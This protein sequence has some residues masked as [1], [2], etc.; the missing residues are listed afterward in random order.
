MRHSQT[1]AAER[2]PQQKRN[3]QPCGTSHLDGTKAS[4]GRLQPVAVLALCTVPSSRH[5]ALLHSVQIKRGLGRVCGALQC[6]SLSGCLG[7]AAVDRCTAPRLFRATSP[8]HPFAITVHSCVCTHSHACSYSRSRCSAMQP[9]RASPHS[10]TCQLAQ[11]MHPNSVMPCPCISTSHRTSRRPNTSS[12]CGELPA[13]SCLRRAARRH[14]R[15][16]LTPVLRH[17]PSSLYGAPHAKLPLCPCIFMAHSTAHQMPSAHRAH[18]ISTAHAPHQWSPPAQRQRRP[19][20]KRAFK[21]TE[22]S[23]AAAQDR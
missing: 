12:S 1:A 23:C 6:E 22:G 3:R 7:M 14:H 11:S 10:T 13:G 9:C 21:R 18:S 20:M 5:R 15:H 16:L 4:S 17:G 2:R 8:T 19:N